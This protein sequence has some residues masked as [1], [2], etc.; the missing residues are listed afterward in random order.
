MDARN[1][2][3]LTEDVVEVVWGGDVEAFVEAGKHM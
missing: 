1:M 2:R 3:V